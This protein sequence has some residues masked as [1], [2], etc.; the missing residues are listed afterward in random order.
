[1]FRLIQWRGLVIKPEDLPSFPW[2][3]IE[4]VVCVLA[5]EVVFYYSHRMLHHPRIYKYIHKKHHEWVAPIAITSLYAHPVEHI[6]S[7]LLPPFVG[8]FLLG[9]HVA[10]TWLWYTIAALSTLNAHSGFHFPF[11]PS[12]EAHDYHH[13]KFNQNYGVLGILD[14]LHGTDV[15]FRNSPIYDRH[16]MLLSLVPL[17]Q[18]YPDKEKKCVDMGSGEC[19]KSK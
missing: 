6:L 4:L 12:P 17:K 9:S 2:V 16:I 15:N 18:L 14:R 1:M 5:E 3:L 7:N 8:P 11:F 10:T 19:S 13:L